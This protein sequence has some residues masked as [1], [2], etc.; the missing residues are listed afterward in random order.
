MLFKSR[1][2]KYFL[3]P[4]KLYSLTL[5]LGGI[6]MVIISIIL[7]WRNGLNMEIYEAVIAGILQSLATYCMMYSLSRENKGFTPMIVST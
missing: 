7:V 3:S 6:P 2:L 4:Y 1:I 5:F